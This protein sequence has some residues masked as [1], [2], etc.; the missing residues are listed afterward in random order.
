ML[1]V[2]RP[3]TFRAHI[4]SYGLKEMDSGA[5]AVTIHC[6]LVSMFHDGEWIDWP[7]G[8][9]EA[10]GDVWIIK[11]K[12]SGGGLNENGVRSLID[13]AGWDGNIES[14]QSAT[15]TPTKCAV[16]IQESEYKGKKS[17]KV[18]FVNDYNRT[19]GAMSTLDPA[20]AKQLQSQYGAQL[21]AMAGNK[22]RAATPPPNSR[23]APPPALQPVGPPP[24]NEGDIPF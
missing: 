5:V 2:D 13:Y 12:E 8:T 14:I 21:R 24:E 10:D 19:P 11:K 6:E 20:K 15:W 3:G 16:V 7:A 22:A 1:P 4:A 23:P 17:L 9:M 18:A